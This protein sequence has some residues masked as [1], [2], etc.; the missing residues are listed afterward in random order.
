MKLINRA[1][2][3]AFV[4]TAVILVV[5]LGI[6]NSNSR[7]FSGTL[8]MVPFAL[9]PLLLSLLLALVMPNKAS[10]ITLIIGS[11]FY[12]GFFIH[13]YGGLFHRSPSPQSGIGLLFIGFYSLRVMIPMWYVAAF[14]S[15]YKRIKNPDPPKQDPPI[16]KGEG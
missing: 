14:L 3:P 16:R 4:V 8:F 1:C 10:Q 12:S 5:G 9:G 15:I 11:V 2:S 7:S 6:L 13:L